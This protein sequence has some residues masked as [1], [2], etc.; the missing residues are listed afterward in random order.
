[1]SEHTCT[2]FP[3]LSEDAVLLAGL[4]FGMGMVS[5][6]THHLR[7]S[8]PS[9]R[10]QAAI[11]E[12]LAKSIIKVEPFNKYGGKVYTPLVEC[13]PAFMWLSKAL[14]DEATHARLSWQVMEP[15]PSVRSAIHQATNPQSHGSE[16]HD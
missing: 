3:Q 16:S 10:T 7:E 1:M 12:L 14:E 5:K 15:I 8:R 9:P 2:D 6:V 13:R 4:W 11:D